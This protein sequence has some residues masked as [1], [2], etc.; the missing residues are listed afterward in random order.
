MASI[1]AKPRSHDSA[2]VDNVRAVVVRTIRKG[3]MTKTQS[4]GSLPFRP[5]SL[6]VLLVVGVATLF[7]ACASTP[8]Q[9]STGG[10]VDDSTITAKVKSNLAQDAKVSASDVHVK[11]YKGVVDLSG[12]VNSQSEIPEAKLVASQV[13]GVKSV[14]DNLIVKGVVAPPTA[15]EQRV[16]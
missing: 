12:F 13:P 16:D 2:I 6:A 11:T 15:A 8:T 9:E 14:H 1:S 5:R 3:F 4:Y 7:A 10:Y